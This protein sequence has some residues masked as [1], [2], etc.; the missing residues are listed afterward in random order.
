MSWKLRCNLG[1]NEA[2]E[3]PVPPSAR[4]SSMAHYNNLRSLDRLS[5]KMHIV[6]S[7][8]YVSG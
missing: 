3:N 5:K 1:G 6:R 2:T 7:N 4:T 8:H